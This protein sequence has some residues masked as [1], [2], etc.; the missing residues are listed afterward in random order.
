MRAPPTSPLP[1]T[2]TS[3]AACQCRRCRATAGCLATG[4][5]GWWCRGAD[6]SLALDGMDGAWDQFAENER[7]FGV[8]STWD[9]EFYTTTIDKSATDYNER[10]LL[11][12]RIASQIENEARSKTTSNVHLLEER[13]FDLDDGIDEEDRYGAVVRDAAAP[14]ADTA[15][16]GAGAA[17][18]AAAAAVDDAA[19]AAAKAAKLQQIGSASAKRDK[20][21]AKV[22]AGPVVRDARTVNALN[23]DPPAKP[24]GRS[25]QRNSGS[26]RPLR[27]RPRLPTPPPPT[28]LLPTP[29][30]LQPLP[31]PPRP[32]P[33]RRHPPLHQHRQLLQRPHRPLRPRR[34]LVLCALFDHCRQ[35]LVPK[36]SSRCQCRQ[37]PQRRS[38]RSPRRCRFSRRLRPPI[39]PRLCSS[40][41][42]RRNHLNNNSNN[43][44]N[45]SSNSSSN[46]RRLSNACANS[47]SGR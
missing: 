46:S 47:S 9:E 1:P 12:E 16:A 4:R 40:D 13:G 36:S 31:P 32:L 20:D 6:A 3:A 8:K 41:R 5:C 19:A 30:H 7:K 44:N 37:R 27:R 26:A 11:A 39:R 15:A 17:A 22:V 28:R 23:L 34:A 45:N 10:R 42:R 29:H 18:A 33:R 43:S 24:G 35:R 25:S 14:A 2:P 21:K 38:R